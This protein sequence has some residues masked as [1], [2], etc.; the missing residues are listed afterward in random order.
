[1]LLHKEVET[2]DLADWSEI[3]QNFLIW[4]VRK[5]DV[6]KIFGK[7]VCLNEVGDVLSKELDTNVVCLGIND[8]L[9]ADNI[10]VCAFVQN[11]NRRFVE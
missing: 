7:K 4:R 1:M 8:T 2:G 6:V 10:G 11:N 5:D 3:N 9:N